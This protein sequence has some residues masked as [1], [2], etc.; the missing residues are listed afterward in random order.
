MYKIKR[1]HFSQISSTNDYAK[2]L[3]ASE[4]LVAV[5]ADY[6][7][8]GRGRGEK[9]WEGEQARNVYCSIGM[10]HH[11]LLRMEHLIALQAQGCLAAKQA[12]EK[13]A[14]GKRFSLKYPNDVLLQ[15]EDGVWRKI[16][17]VLVEHEFTGSACV[18]TVVGIGIN[19][20][21][22]NFPATLQNR[23]TSLLNEDIN[24]QV[25]TVTESLLRQWEILA[26]KQAE[27]ILEY[28]KKELHIEGKVVEIVGEGQGWIVKKLLADGRL[29]TRHIMSGTERI[30]DNGDSIRYEIG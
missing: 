11:T 10:R 15:S 30:I 26:E 20:R 14:P 6:Q 22:K 27:V 24:V 13:A 7:W 8:N 16:C 21:Q 3:I 23:A 9:V 29:L 4:N 25:E 18:S 17:G 19:I 2:E 28:W 1:Y 5:T 12:L